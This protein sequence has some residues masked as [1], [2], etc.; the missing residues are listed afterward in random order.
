MAINKIGSRKIIVD[1]K[2]FRWSATGNDGWISIAIWP[3]DVDMKI[4]GIFDYHA[5]YE[6][7][8]DDD[9]PYTK[10]QG[11]I[12]ITNRVIRKIIDYVTVEK[13]IQ[14]KGI[15]DLGR[16][17]SIYNIDNALFEPINDN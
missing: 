12:I 3:V 14:L 10:V 17:E 2:E 11:Q 5:K 13:I 7:S 4:V 9:K 8:S 6:K 1:N 16:L 15:V